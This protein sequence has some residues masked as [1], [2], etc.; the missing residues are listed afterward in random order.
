MAITPTTSAPP[1]APTE[2]IALIAEWREN[3]PFDVAGQDTFRVSLG[4]VAERRFF[5]ACQHWLQHAAGD[6]TAPVSE[7]LLAEWFP[8]DQSA[9]CPGERDLR[10][11]VARAHLRC[12]EAGLKHLS[13]TAPRE[14]LVAISADLELPLH[15]VLGIAADLGA[16]A[17][18]ESETKPLGAA[19]VNVMLVAGH[20]YPFVLVLEARRGSRPALYAAPAFSLLPRDSTWLQTERDAFVLFQEAGLWPENWEVAWS[21]VSWEGKLPGELEGPSAGLSFFMGLGKLIAQHSRLDKLP[22][23]LSALRGLDLE[24]VVFSAALKRVAPGPGNSSQPQPKPDP[25]SSAWQLGQVSRVL[26]KVS[27]SI[28]FHSI[29][30]AE[31]QREALRQ[32]LLDGRAN[33]RVGTMQFQ[34][35][36]TPAQAVQ[37]TAKRVGALRGAIRD[38]RE[39]LDDPHYAQFDPRPEVLLPIEEFLHGDQGGYRLLVADPWF[40]KT[41]IACHLVRQ[42]T[43]APRPGWRLAYHFLRRSAGGLD[44]PDIALRSLIAQIRLGAGLADDKEIRREQ[45]ADEFQQTLRQAAERLA[46]AGGDARLL[47]LIDGTDETFGPLAEKA[48]S[49]PFP[50]PDLL[51]KP[52]QWPE[53]LQAR[54]RF[55]LFGRPGDYLGWLNNPAWQL[56]LTPSGRDTPERIGA[57]VHLLARRQGLTMS[58]G[59]LQR[60][61]ENAEGLLGLAYEILRRDDL[62]AR[63]PEWEKDH[64][65]VPRGWEGVF[66]DLWKRLVAKAEEAGVP[67]SVVARTLCWIAQAREPLSL[68]LLAEALTA[69]GQGTEMVGHLRQV[70]SLAAEFLTPG[71]KADGANGTARMGAEAPRRFFHT[72]FAEMVLRTEHNACGLTTLELDD[73]RRQ[74]AE[75]CLARWSDAKSKLRPY[76]LPH[77]PGHLIELADGKTLAGLLLN[78]SY[79]HARMESAGERPDRRIYD[80]LHD[81]DLALTGPCAANASLAE[82][83][84][85]LDAR[86]HLLTTH[87]ERLLEQMQHYRDWSTAASKQI[88]QSLNKALSGWHPAVWLKRLNWDGSEEASPLLR[89]LTG[90]RD[91]CINDEGLEPERLSSM[92]QAMRSNCIYS[93]VFSPDGKT[94]ASADRRG[95]IRLW[96]AATGRPRGEPLI[97]H[98]G[99]ICS[100]VYSPDGQTLASMGRDE[101]IRLWD[102]ATGQPRGEPLIGHAGWICSVVFSPDGKTLASA[103]EDKTIRLW[104]AATGRLRGEPLTGHTDEICSVMYSPDGQ[105]LASRGWDET[106]RL[107]D[108]G[109]GRPRCEP[110]TGHAGWICSVVFSPDGQTLASADGHR[111][112][113]LWDAAT[114]RPRGEW[115]TGQTGF[116]WDVVFSPDGQTLAIKSSD[117]MDS[118]PCDSTI[119]L[120]DATKRRP[121]G[122]PLTGHRDAIISVVFSPDGQTLAGAGVDGTIRLW[123]AATGRPRGEWLT[124]HTGRIES[125]VFSSDGKTLASAG[126]DG[127]ILL[128]DATTRGPRRRPL[129]GHMEF[130]YSLVF[131]PDGRTL[132]SAGEDA[133]IRLWDAVTGRPRGELLGHMGRI[134]SVVFSPDGQ[135]LAS[136]DWCGTIRLWDAATGQL[137]GEP[138]TGHTSGINF[139]VFSPDGQTL[140][141]AGDDRTIRLWDAVTGQPRGEPLTGHTREIR[142]VV[143]L[144]DGHTLASAS[145]DGTIRL[146][147]AATGLSRGESL[148]GHPRG[149]SSVVLSPDRQTLACVAF[150]PTI[151]LWDATTRRPRGEP[152]TKHRDAIISVVFSPNG[153]TLASGGKD[154]TIRL[155]DAVTG[156][157][158]R[159]PLTGHTDGIKS[160]VFSPDGQT[161]ASAGD[162]HTIRLWDARTGSLRSLASLFG[163]IHQLHFVE[164]TSELRAAVEDRGHGRISAVRF[165]LMR[166]EARL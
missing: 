71:R 79:L 89:T 140:A 20:G 36:E 28:L 156:R 136:T 159:E 153:Q 2:F 88:H 52:D 126:E 148:T 141:S 81:F 164:S 87:P 41:A 119:Q 129:T 101:T 25:A 11:R 116:H 4:D 7:A 165:R 48:V 24:G 120:W 50:W 63:L 21:L 19:R 157:P 35:A 85:A 112:I 55:L 154:A 68:N 67:M 31:E 15:L 44:T 14:E 103:S 17:L 74:F 114:G 109:T 47:V 61:A 95:T 90:H 76:A 72:Q 135:T 40:G 121:R 115:R 102:A 27:Q 127:T 152:L 123:D 43:E 139:V 99:W 42:L 9:D 142:S 143:F 166:P 46:A 107:W 94:L 26:D 158:R 6:P 134:G 161:L 131:S 106:I 56:S 151:Q 64:A 83:R 10:R 73:W 138:L 111:T 39:V 51:P 82:V 8:D 96:D 92:A 149:I 16:R 12:V 98:A 147:D 130:I 65:L 150:A 137:R 108:A 146:W 93:V 75:A 62:A 86:S 38:C 58:G 105:T 3:G 128:W 70:L 1:A 30:V 33:H 69:N 54:L 104:D 97:G 133:T 45:L 57:C 32:T 160:V 132:A 91:C 144:L 53:S 117:G 80:L 125:V 113:R 100:V 66:E 155:W 124:G 110:L 13:R 5:K 49:R 118:A 84:Q 23:H 163:T 77:L 34:Y 59:L 78:F 145:K 122:E 18:L 22:F 162:D 37:E 29:V 60:I